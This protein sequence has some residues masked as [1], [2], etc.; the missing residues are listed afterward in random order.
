MIRGPSCNIDP[1]KTVRNRDRVPTAPYEATVKMRR[2]E[3]RKGTR[4][5]ATQA[6]SQPLCGIEMGPVPGQTPPPPIPATITTLPT[7]PA[8]P[9][10]PASMT[11][12]E[13]ATLVITVTK[14]PAGI[15]EYDWGERRHCTGEDGDCRGPN[16]DLAAIGPLISTS[17]HS[18]VRT[19]QG[20]PDE[21]EP[22][23]Q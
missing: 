4:P 3:G 6:I 13:P 22:E 7:P 21:T 16:L 5:T 12:T 18:P 1:E 11:A 14:V 10:T 23:Q 9:S 2:L 17:T 20:E 8:T 19:R 15:P